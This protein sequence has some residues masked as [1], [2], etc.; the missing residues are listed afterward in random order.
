MSNDISLAIDANEFRSRIVRRASSRKKY[1][2]RM[3]I[4]SI[5]MVT[6]LPVRSHVQPCTLDEH[7]GKVGN[8]SSWIFP[9]LIDELARSHPPL[10]SSVTLEQWHANADSLMI[11]LDFFF[12]RERDGRLFHRS[13][14][15]E[16]LVISFFFFFLLINDRELINPV[17]SN[18]NRNSHNLIK[19]FCNW[20]DYN[21]ETRQ[22]FFNPSTRIS[23]TCR[24]KQMIIS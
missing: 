15:I 6:F 23:K 13:S 17:F 14:L 22:V 16:F 12:Q 11:L 4:R 2:P 8:Q 18:F 9:R 19:S 5:G 21:L 24:L 10:E 3:R 7:A 1:T 20:N